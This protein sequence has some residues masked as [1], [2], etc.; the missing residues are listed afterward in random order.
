MGKTRALVSVPHRSMKPGPRTAGP[1]STGKPASTLR[2]WAWSMTTCGLT[3]SMPC[4]ALTHTMTGRFAPQNRSP[5]VCL[6]KKCLHFLQN[7]NAAPQPRL[8][9]VGCRRWLGAATAPRNGSLLPIL[10]TCYATAEEGYACQALFWSPCAHHTHLIGQDMA[11]TIFKACVCEPVS[12][13]VFRIGLPLVKHIQEEQIAS[14]GFWGR[15][16]RVVEHLPD[17]IH[18]TT[19]LDELPDVPEHAAGL[20]WRQPWQKPEQDGD[21]K[22]TAQGLLHSI[23]GHDVHPLHKSCF[24]YIALRDGGHRRQIHD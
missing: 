2:G 7:T 8:E 14:H 10:Y 19:W 6:N 18:D 1:A 24:F 16:T 17:D 11:F 21:V 13:L 5:E 9:G 3:A 4:G 23:G 20:V 12:M 15:K 22:R